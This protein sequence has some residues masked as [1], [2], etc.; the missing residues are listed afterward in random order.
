MATVRDINSF[1]YPLQKLG[2][3]V[4]WTLQPSPPPEHECFEASSQH[5][6]RFS[7]WAVATM[8]A[9]HPWGSNRSTSCL[10]LDK[11]RSHCLWV[12]KKSMVLVT[13]ISGSIM[14]YHVSMVVVNVAGSSY[15][16]PLCCEA[17]SKFPRYVCCFSPYSRE[18]KHL[19]PSANKCRRSQVDILYIY[20]R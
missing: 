17:V 4:F 11:I 20:I 15:L 5:G 9:Q 1:G 6:Q 2:A 10:Y 13:S 14:M 18:A 3:S 8:W 7:A 16:L 19:G 12:V